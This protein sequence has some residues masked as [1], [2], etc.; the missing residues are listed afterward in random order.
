[1]DTALFVGLSHR[2]A[3]RRRMDVVAHNIANMTTAA[4]NKERVVFR[5][6]LVE[7]PGATATQSGKISYVQDYGIVRNLEIGAATTSS[8]P[9]DVFINGRGYLSVQGTDGDT[10]YTRNGRMTIDRDNELALLS[11]EKVLDDGGA[12]IQIS[13][14]D[15]DLHIAE[16]GSISSNNGEIAKLSLF[17]FGNEQAM[18][19]RGSSL[20]ETDQT[21]R[22]PEDITKVSFKQK[23]YEGSNVNAIESMVEMINVSR[24]YQNADKA[25]NDYQDLRKDALRRLGK[26]Q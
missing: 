4:F 2:A 14:E 9:L 20:Y 25:S 6:L 16:D 8:N 24:A 13:E 23:A 5:Q 12:T 21:P 10:L 19:R 15:V 22:E 26:V 17:Q 18:K 1:M 11:G 3:L 7:T